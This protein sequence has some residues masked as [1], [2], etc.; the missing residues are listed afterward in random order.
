M[1]DM[2]AT[3]CLSVTGSE[4]FFSSSVKVG[5]A[6]LQTMNVRLS[7]R[8]TCCSVIGAEICVACFMWS[9]LSFKNSSGKKILLA[10][11][12]CSSL[13]VSPVSPPVLF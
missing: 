9:W 2:P 12:A 13:K 8:L 5:P 4:V 6:N 1:C 3:V 7:D 11:L 10:R